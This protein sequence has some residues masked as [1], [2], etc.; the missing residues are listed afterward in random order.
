M[1]TGEAPRQLWGRRALGLA[2]GGG[3]VGWIIAYVGLLMFVQLLG[4]IV[5]GPRGP[6]EID[7][8]LAAVLLLGALAYG[9]PCGAVVGLVIWSVWFWVCRRS[10]VPDSHSSPHP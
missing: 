4:Q 10:R 8:D 2:L 3:I 7:P 9:V 1:K 6:T 5:V